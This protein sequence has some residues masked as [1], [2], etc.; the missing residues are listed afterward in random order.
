MA[1]DNK[2]GILDRYRARFPWFDHV[3]RMQER[4]QNVKGNF[5][6]AGITYFTVFALFPLMMVGFAVAGFVL[7]RQPE[8][9]AELRTRISE[10]VSGEVGNQLIN[11][12]DTAIA[13]R[14][15]LGLVGLATAAWAGLG[16]MANVREALTAMWE[17]PDES[18][19]FVKGKLSDL[20]ALASTFLALALTIAVTAVGD[21]ATIMRILGWVGLHDVSVPAPLLKLATVTVAIVVSWA[22]FTW[23]IARL[24]RQRLPFASSARAGLIAAIGFELFKQV[25]SIYLKVIMHGPAGSTF[26]PILGIMVF[27]YITARLLLYATAW[28]ATSERAM[29]MAP[30]L[31][32]Q[33]AIISTRLETSSRPSTLGVIAAVS[34]GALGALG[35]SWLGRGRD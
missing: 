19:G 6:A 18:V 2:P 27:A 15:S 29:L 17:Q 14:A 4:Y 25:A 31:P 7:S 13:S 11:L 9:I 34:A 21:E 3:M 23:M 1:D 26:G 24:P 20:L 12:M 33:P 8:T 32:P 5:Y 35:I 16:W 22:L 10:T 28:A 30:V